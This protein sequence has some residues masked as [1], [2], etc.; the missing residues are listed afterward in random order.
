[1]DLNALH[2]VA[3]EPLTRELDMLEHGTL[4]LDAMVRMPTTG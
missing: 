2:L 4:L 1:M 3:Y